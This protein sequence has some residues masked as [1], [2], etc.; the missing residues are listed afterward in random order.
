[1]SQLPT[2]PNNLTGDELYDS[3]MAK[4]EPE[5]LTANLP[6]IKDLTQNETPDQRRARAARYTAAFA[7][8][9]TAFK[10]NVKEWG[11]L[12]HSFV[13]QTMKELEHDLASVE[14]DNLASLEAS[15]QAS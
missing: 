14:Q 4:I 2:P 11:K 5:L 10:A 3:I 9:D 12:F 6:R 15:M 13:S 7:A 8:Y 1:M